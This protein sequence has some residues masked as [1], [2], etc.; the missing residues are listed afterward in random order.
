MSTSFT[1]RR[2]MSVANVCRN[3]CAPTRG[4]PARSHARRVTSLTRSGLIPRLGALQEQIPSAARSAASVGEVFGQRPADVDRQRHPVL[5]GRACRAQQSGRRASQCRPTAASPPRS[6]AAPAARPASKSRSPEPGPDHR[7]H[8]CPAATARDRQAAPWE[9]P[10]R[11]IPRPEEP[12]WSTSAASNRA[13]TGISA[14]TQFGHPALGRSDADPLAFA[15]QERHH[16]GPGQRRGLDTVA[17]PVQLK[18][19]AG[20][21]LVPNDRRF[22]QARSATSHRR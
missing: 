8:S 19:P 1:P 4:S 14:V 15:Q 9:C 3:R 12:P 22:R 2:S 18:E 7:D 16:L 20:E 13:R 21:I 17:D 10:S 5:A 6:S 11:A